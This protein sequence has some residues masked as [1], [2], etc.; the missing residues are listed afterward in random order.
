MKHDCSA[1][2][3]L[4]LDK[5]QLRVAQAQRHVIGPWMQSTQ[6]SL[7]RIS[8]ALL[9]LTGLCGLS[10]AQAKQAAAKSG[11]Q[12]PIANDS[13][14]ARG[15]YIVNHVAVC[16]QCHTPRDSEGR[17]ER[18]HWLEGAALWL[19]SAEP[20]ADWPL[21]APRIGGALPGTDDEMITLLTTGIWRSGA[22]L[23][24]PMPQFRMTR[25]DAEA[26]VA[27]LKSVKPAPK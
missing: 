15:E 10:L 26:V 23:R 7:R 21:R 22:Y 18:T 1:C 20:V 14:T 4:L 6:V 17:P 3:Q 16:S 19:Q 5:D 13:A 2:R 8:Q 25:P 11:S 24:A 12:A 27:Y 9:L